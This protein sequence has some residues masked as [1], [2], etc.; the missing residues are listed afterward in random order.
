MNNHNSVQLLRLVTLLPL[1]VVLAAI[2][3][4][5]RLDGALPDWQPD[6]Q[7]VLTLSDQP[8]QD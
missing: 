4:E 5:G 7:L 3:F 2:V 1:I 6:P 8:F